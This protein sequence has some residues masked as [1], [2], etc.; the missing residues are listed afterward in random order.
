MASQ[1]QDWAAVDLVS[2]A[3]SSGG[4]GDDGVENDDGGEGGNEDLSEQQYAVQQQPEVEARDKQR[5]LEAEQQ[6]GWNT[7]QWLEQVLAPGS[8]GSKLLQ[9]Q[10][11]HCD[12]SP[13][14]QHFR[15]GTLLDALRSDDN[16][17]D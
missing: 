16:Y 8:D 13:T 6:A 10:T 11:C 7:Q 1:V 9:Y 15:W 12:H 5:L 4:G 17:A 3:F 2:Q 14:H